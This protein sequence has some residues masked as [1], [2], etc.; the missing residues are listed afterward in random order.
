MLIVKKSPLY[1]LDLEIVEESLSH[2]ILKNKKSQKKSITHSCKPQTNI[3]RKMKEQMRAIKSFEHYFETEAQKVEGLRI[4]EEI[5]SLKCEIERKHTDALRCP[6]LTKIIPFQFLP[7]S[8]DKVEIIFPHVDSP[9]NQ[10]ILSW[11]ANDVDDE[12]NKRSGCGR[13]SLVTLDSIQS[14]ESILLSIL[15]SQPEVKQLRKENYLSSHGQ[16]SEFLP[17]GSVAR[18]LYSIM[19]DSDH[20]T[21]FIPRQFRQDGLGLSIVS[22]IFQRL[23]LMAM[24]IM[25]LQKYY[26]C[27]F[28]ILPKS[29]TIHLHVTITLGHSCSLGLRFTYD[30]SDQRTILYSMPS[31]VYI[32]PITGEPAVPINILLRVAQFTLAT[33]PICNAFILKRTCS[34]IVDTLQGRT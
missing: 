24:D 7:R 28:E 19:L 22:D 33:E 3:K 32:M 12:N 6:T 21:T 8:A 9:H 1:P 27:R 34:A 29:S 26:S 5:W 2:Y 31:D 25:V 30:L 11:N 16:H 14:S 18:D 20:M 10:T 23:A 15:T 17:S 4:E 13:D